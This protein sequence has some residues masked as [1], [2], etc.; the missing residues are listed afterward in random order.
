MRSIV[1]LLGTLRAS[2]FKRSC[3]KFY[4]LFENFIQ[5]FEDTGNGFDER[6]LEQENSPVFNAYWRWM[7]EKVAEVTVIPVEPEE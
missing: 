5:L 7:R 2:R 3:E 6:Y 1:S 4:R